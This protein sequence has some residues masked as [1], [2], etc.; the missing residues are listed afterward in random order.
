MILINK[1]TVKSVMH[2][3]QLRSNP[4]CDEF[5]LN[6]KEYK[7]KPTGQAAQQCEYIEN[8]IKTQSP[9]FLSDPEYWIS[10][11]EDITGQDIPSVYTRDLPSEITG[12]AGKVRRNSPTL[13]LTRYLPVI[14]ADG[15]KIEYSNKNRLVGQAKTYILKEDLVSQLAAPCAC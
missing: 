10:M 12:V 8:L 11:W 6:K 9:A 5:K 13:Y 7:N 2:M 1:Y 3:L 14:K 4:I 15:T